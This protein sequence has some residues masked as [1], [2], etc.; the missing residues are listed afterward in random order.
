[1]PPSEAYRQLTQQG[2][3][4]RLGRYFVH[5]DATYSWPKIED[6][7]EEPSSLAQDRAEL[8]NICTL[9]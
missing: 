2:A 7:W 3:R 4:A 9:K 8:G 1:M 6:L 5:A